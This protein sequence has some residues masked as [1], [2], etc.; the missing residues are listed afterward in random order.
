MAMK[1]PDYMTV[2]MCDPCHHRVHAEG[3]G[4]KDWDR[5]REA[6]IPLLIG[7]LEMALDAERGF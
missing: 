1:P 7:C 4:T 3:Y 5:V 6:L 2:P